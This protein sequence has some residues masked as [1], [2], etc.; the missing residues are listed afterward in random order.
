MP[1]QIFMRHCL[2]H[3]AVTVREPINNKGK[4]DVKKKKEKLR[5]QAGEPFIIPSIILTIK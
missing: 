4:R 3:G 5:A 1:H 2:R